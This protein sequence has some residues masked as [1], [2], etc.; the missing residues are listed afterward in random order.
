MAPAVERDTE[1]RHCKRGSVGEL[2]GRAR[3]GAGRQGTR[4]PCQGEEGSCRMRRAAR[5]AGNYGR[6]HTRVPRY[7]QGWRG[8]SNW[9]G[10]AWANG[11]YHDRPEAGSPDQLPNARRTRPT[12]LLAGRA[13]RCHCASS[14][15]N[16]A[17]SAATRL[18]S[19][20]DPKHLHS[21]AAYHHVLRPLMPPAEVLWAPGRRDLRRD[22]PLTRTLP[23]RACGP[24]QLRHSPSHQHHH[25]GPESIT[26]SQSL[27]LHPPPS[28]AASTG[29]HVPATAWQVL[30][31]VH[32]RTRPVRF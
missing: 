26:A 30:Q 27:Q 4:P 23:R 9:T 14:P 11:S 3:G 2:H 7:E 5:L 17:L 29:A 12:R 28:R 1:A 24:G 32:S 22:L 16:T 19:S 13:T 31:R 20:S 6:C 18:L 25:C 10:A 15:R 21:P 8:S